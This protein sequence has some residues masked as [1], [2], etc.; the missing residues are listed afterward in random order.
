MRILY[1]GD[2]VGRAGRQAVNAIL[3]DYRRDLRLDLVLVN[4]ENSA[5]GF[6]ITEPIC[7]ELVQLGADVILTGN[8]AWDQRDILDSVDDIPQLIRPA[9]YPDG[10]PGRGHAV[11]ETSGGKQILVLQ[12]MGRAF[13]DPLDDPFRVA[14]DI[15]QPFELGHNIDGII[16]DIHGEATAEKMAFGHY[17]DGRVS[18]V[19]GTHTHVPTADAMILPAGTAYQTDLGM[20]GDYD[21]VI[22]MDKD[23]PIQRFVRKIPGGRF[24]PAMGTA[25][26]CG[27]LVQLDEATGLAQSIEVLRDGPHLLPAMPRA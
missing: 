13:M 26:V 23:E 3:P 5:G 10:T 12:L 4:G 22:G 17:L 27:V 24:V 15:L 2:I 16:V 18:A 7:R 19:L 11:F 8:H 25:T 1:L 14:D 20:C 9:N 6:G 21:S